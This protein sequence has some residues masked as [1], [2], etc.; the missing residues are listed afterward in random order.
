MIGKAG[1]VADPLGASEAKKAV[2]KRRA[3]ST[4]GWNGDAE[5]CETS[6]PGERHHPVHHQ[7]HR[8]PQVHHHHHVGHHAAYLLRED[9]ADH[10]LVVAEHYSKPHYLGLLYSYL[11]GVR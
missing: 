10:V 9:A 8:P 6:C 7:V 11:H 1:G 2:G 4:T 5:G 3:S